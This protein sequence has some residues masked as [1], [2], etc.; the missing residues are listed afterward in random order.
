MSSTNQDLINQ[1]PDALDPNFLY[2]EMTSTDKTYVDQY[3]TYMAAND[4]P[5]ANALFATYPRLEGLIVT[6]QRMQY[7]NDE[8]LSLERFYFSDF[9]KYITTAVKY[10]GAY[11]PSA[12]YS[13]LNVVTYNYKAY[14][15]MSS[16]CP[17]GT[18]PTSTTYW[19]SLTLEGISGTGMAFYTSWS[20]SQAY[21]LQDCVPYA[22]VLYVCIQAHTNQNPSTATAYWSSVITVPKQILISSSQPSGQGTDELWYEILS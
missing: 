18:L 17:I 10:K 16:S 13:M 5:S 1:F 11:S 15:C 14:Q 7:H 9:Q 12:A 2:Y 22:G 4:I 8:I 19:V 6:S 3:Y 21:K 20:N